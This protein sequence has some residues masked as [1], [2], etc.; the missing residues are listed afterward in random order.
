MR[1]V[2]L[3]PSV[4]GDRRAYLLVFG[5][6]EREPTVRQSRRPWRRNALATSVS[7]GPYS[8]PGQSPILRSAG[9]DR[10]PGDDHNLFDLGLP[11]NDRASRD[12]APPDA[13]ADL[14][15]RAC[16]P[17]G[18]RASGGD[19]RHNQPG[20]ARPPAKARAP[21]GTSSEK[22]CQHQISDSFRSNRPPAKAI[23]RPNEITVSTSGTSRQTAAIFSGASTVTCA[24]GRPRLIA[25]TGGNA[26]NTI[27]RAN[28]CRG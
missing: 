5:R 2:Q 20:A 3:S 21:R 14:F 15:V 19:A 26:D 18:L 28:C 24:S 12:N 1:L 27:A 7:P 17:S 4:R 6:A 11:P 13:A 23:F 8:A 25:R 9:S 16:E 22:Q 10:R